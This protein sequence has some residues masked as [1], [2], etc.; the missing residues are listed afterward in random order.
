[1]CVCVD[2][3]HGLMSPQIAG[4]KKSGIEE[5]KMILQAEA[6]SWELLE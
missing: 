5:A 4:M 1:M 3:V 6:S 2:Y